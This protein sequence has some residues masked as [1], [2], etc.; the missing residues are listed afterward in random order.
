ML[1][2]LEFPHYDIVTGFRFQD[3]KTLVLKRLHL[4]VV[5]MPIVYQFQCLGSFNCLLSVFLL[6]GLTNQEPIQKITPSQ[7][8]CWRKNQTTTLGSLCP[9]SFR[10]VCGTIWKSFFQNHNVVSELIVELSTWFSLTVSY[11]R[12]V[13]WFSKIIMKPY[14]KSWPS[15]DV[16]RNLF[17]FSDFS[18]TTWLQESLAITLPP[19]SL[20]MYKRA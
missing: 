13:V 15:L 4:D 1:F 2:L 12:R 16:L 6:R 11:K 5:M 17:I 19:M 8:N 10:I 20:S 14:G 7:P 9:Y 3:L 18:K